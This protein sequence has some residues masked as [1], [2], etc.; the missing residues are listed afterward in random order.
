[1]KRFLI[2]CLSVLLVFSLCA[3][4]KTEPTEVVETPPVVEEPSTDTSSEYN[5][6]GE[7][8]KEYADEKFSSLE[9]NKFIGTAIVKIRP[10]EHQ[11]ADIPIISKD[12]PNAEQVF[13]LLHLD[14]DYLLNYAIS[15]SANSTRAYTF[16]VMQSAP[17][18]EEYIINSVEARLA[19]LYQQV[20][21]YPDQLYLVDNAIITQ[22]GDFVVFIVCDNADRVYQELAKVF[23]SMDLNTIESVPYMTDAE[24]EVLENAAFKED[25]SD[26]FSDVGEVE[27]TPVDENG[28]IIENETTE[29]ETSK[30]TD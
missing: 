8:L 3:C 18:C 15:A 22:L 24:R 14:P 2:S 21:D 9:I 16:A 23:D 20:K 6:K 25:T 29:T 19:D 1:M 26:L 7:Y 28:V 17:Y 27:V 4:G 13:T 11:I 12:S 30:T 10:E 5:F